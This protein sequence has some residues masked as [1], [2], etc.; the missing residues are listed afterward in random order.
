VKGLR[1]HYVSIPRELRTPARAARQAAPLPFPT[2]NAVQP[3]IIPRSSW[4][5]GNRCRPRSTPGLG[6]IQTAIV[7][8]TV[9]LN[10]YSR[11]QAASMVL[12]ICLFHRDGNGWNDIGYNFLVDRYGQVFEGRAGG[13]DQPVVGAHA[14]GFNTPSTGI[15]VIGNFSRTPPPKPAMN[16]LAKVLAWKLSIHG[17]PAKGHTTVVSGGGPDTGYK[18]GTRVTLQRISGHRDADL[19]ECPG[20]ALYRRLPALRNQVAKLEG[21]FSRLSLA[22]PAVATQY[23]S[24]V[25]LSGRLSPARGGETIEIRELSAGRE[26]V[27][28]SATT[29]PDGT[30]FAT[31]LAQRSGVFRAVYLG[32][33]SSP[34]VISNVAWVTVTP[35]K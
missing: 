18:A 27:V 13:I 9:S 24:G 7:H 16:A 28:A 29:A 3:K 4:D 32:G 31:P 30:W 5:A 22:V 25:P 20:A 35:A 14:G 2:T 23:G 34:G 21:A 15:S 33:E 8:H 17:V 26:R 12:G 1:L 19:T 11:S 6:R 10:G